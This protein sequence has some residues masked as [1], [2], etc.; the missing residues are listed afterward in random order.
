M[1]VAVLLESVLKKQKR[2]TGKS[3]P[4]NTKGLISINRGLIQAIPTSLPPQPIR[5]AKK[6]SNLQRIPPGVQ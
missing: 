6:A 1:H 5:E 3:N 2:R 4:A